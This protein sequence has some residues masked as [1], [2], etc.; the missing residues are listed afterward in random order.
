MVLALE[1]YG[2]LKEAIM[3]MYIKIFNGKFLGK[4]KEVRQSKPKYLNKKADLIDDDKS[5]LFF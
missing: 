5:Y 1:W 4:Y 3:I 2:D